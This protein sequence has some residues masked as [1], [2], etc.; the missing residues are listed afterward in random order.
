MKLGFLA[1]MYKTLEAPITT[2]VDA[3]F[4]RHLSQ[5][6][7]KIFH[8]DRMLADDSHEILCLFCNF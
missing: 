2:A 3:N 1:T 8:E 6:S 5:F 7:K 4:F